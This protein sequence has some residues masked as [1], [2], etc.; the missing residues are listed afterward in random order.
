[1]ANI[2]FTASSSGT[3]M[4]TAT[5]NSVTGRANVTVSAA[6]APVVTSFLLKPDTSVALKGTIININITALNGNLTQSLFNGIANI[7]IA[8]N[9]VK[10]N[11]APVN[12]SFVN[13]NAT[14][15]VNSSI[16]QFVNV[17]AT[18]GTITGTTMVEFADMVIS[19]SRGYNLISIPSFA[20][21]SD[22]VLAVQLVQNNGVQSFNPATGLFITPTDLQPLYGYW[23]NVTADNQKFGFIAD[24]SVVIMPPTRNLYEGW[25][26]IGLSANR[27]EIGSVTPNSTFADLRNGDLPSQ[28]L[29]SRLVSFDEGTGRFATYTAVWI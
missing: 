24:T 2:T 12:V 21:P 20:N 17:T 7:T 25:N 29:Y 3:A 11:S 1:M 28:W 15:Q 22:T 26:L 13:G 18:N 4:I 14:I 27:N 5:N 9:N 10:C 23:I 19:L 16:A 6:P 8:A